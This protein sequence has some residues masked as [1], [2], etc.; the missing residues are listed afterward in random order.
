MSN[1]SIYSVSECHVWR[2]V[3][4]DGSVV[5]VPVERVTDERGTWWRGVDNHVK[6][7]KERSAAMFSLG[8]DRRD[9]LVELRSA[10]EMTTAEQIA[11]M[12]EQLISMSIAFNSMT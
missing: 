11:A 3:L 5:N 1:D 2:A 10:G 12:R 9:N 4:D 8:V 7:N 6:F